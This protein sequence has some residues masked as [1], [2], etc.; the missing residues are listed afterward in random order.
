MVEGAERLEAREKEK[1]RIISD[2]RRKLEHTGRRNNEDCSDD[3]HRL[4]QDITIKETQIAE[5][6]EQLE[7]EK[8]YRNDIAELEEQLTRMRENIKKKEARIKALEADLDYTTERLNQARGQYEDDLKHLEK[9][10]T[11]IEQEIRERDVRIASLEGHLEAQADAT[12]RERSIHAEDIKDLEDKV[13]GLGNMLRE[14][15]TIL[16]SMQIQYQQQMVTE[17]DY[18]HDLAAI[19]KVNILWW[20][21]GI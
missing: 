5:Y 7:D 20:S 4:K 9:Q 17:E 10:F 15:Q 2:L 14:K 6:R 3:I 18:E 13:N 19:K 8:L 16:S 21:Y 11:E 12:Q 1:D